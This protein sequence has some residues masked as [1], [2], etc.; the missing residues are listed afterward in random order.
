MPLDE[1]AVFDLPDATRE[2][3]D[4]ALAFARDKLAP[5]AQDWDERR[6]LPVDTLREAA[7]LGM[8]ALYVR[9]ESGGAGLSRLD[10]AV[11]FEALAAGWWHDLRLG[12][13]C[14]RHQGL[15]PDQ[16]AQCRA[17]ACALAGDRG[18]DGCA[19]RQDAA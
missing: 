18:E 17:D 11:V 3:R 6:H 15:L 16:G 9:G 8:A 12:G 13:G 5:H 10:A 1:A 7:G 14:R 4:V 19:W 2:L